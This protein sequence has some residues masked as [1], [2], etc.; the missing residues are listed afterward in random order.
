MNA[1]IY[2]AAVVV[3]LAMV[4]VGIG[5]RSVPDALTVVGA[6]VLILTM[7]GARV[8]TRRG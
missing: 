7:Y 2:N 5:L 6:L 8:A 3:G 4:G 1:H